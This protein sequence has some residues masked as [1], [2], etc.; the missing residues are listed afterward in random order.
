MQLSVSAADLEANE[1]PP[2]PTSSADE[3]F[4]IDWNFVKRE[5]A[6]ARLGLDPALDNLPDDDPNKLY[7]KITKV[8]AIRDHYSKSR[9]ESNLSKADN[10][11]GETSRPQTCGAFTD[12]MSFYAAP[13]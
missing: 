6:L 2:S 1:E 12:D 7:A 3:E 13:S 11:R 10:I 5:A 9:P 8:K 4:D